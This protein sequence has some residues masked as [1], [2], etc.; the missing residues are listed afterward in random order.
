ERDDRDVLD[1]DVLP[2]VELG[3]VRE[4]EDADALARADPAVQQMPQ[5]RPLVLRI[6]LSLGVAQR[7]D[8]F[9]RARPLLVAAGS[10]ERRI[11]VAGLEAVEPRLGFQ[12]TAAALGADQEGLRAVGDRFL[13]GMNDQPRAD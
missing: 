13:V 4:R 10:A 6:P 9:L 1:L 8:A 2:D 5:L 3:P 11:E 7:E 12:Q